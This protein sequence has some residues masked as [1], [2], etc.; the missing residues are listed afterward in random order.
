MQQQYPPPNNG[1]YAPVYAQPQ[2]SPYPPPNEPYQQQSYQQQQPYQQQ[3]SQ[4]Q[5]G[6]DK[7]PFEQ[8]F[9]IEKPKYNDL[10]AG[11]LFLAFMAGFTV[12]SA[13]A[14]QGYGMRAPIVFPH[15]HS[16]STPFASC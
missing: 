2:Q 13:I 15:T 11:I 12:V 6:D 3:P 4:F 8:A 7:V 14:L 5:Y 9:K 16:P 1:G 10:W